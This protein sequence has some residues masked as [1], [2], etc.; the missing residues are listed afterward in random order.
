LSPQGAMARQ[1]AKV[2]KQV[3]PWRGQR[4]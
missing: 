3:H 4:T 1:Q 2:A